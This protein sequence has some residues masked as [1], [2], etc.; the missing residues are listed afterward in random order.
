MIFM[1]QKQQTLPILYSYFR[2]SCA[3]RVRLALHLKKIDF[4]YRAVHLLKNGGEQNE[5]SYR[6]LNPQGEVPFWV[7]DQVQMAQSLPIIQYLDERWP[8]PR[9]I[10]P[11][12]KK[13]Y[14]ALELCELINSGIQPL[15]NLK[16]LQRIESQLKGS[17]SDKESWV[18][19]FVSAGLLALENKIKN[20]P[21]YKG[22]FSM[23]DDLSVVDLFI[24]PQMF[25]AD[26][27]KVNLEAYPILRAINQKCL[28]LPEV[29]LAHPKL[30]PDFES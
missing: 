23:G 22:N 29:Q 27:F 13:K 9:L 15:Q 20:S 24:V 11:E 30:Q 2:S 5:T 19:H 17:A 7:D 18:H 4:E 14:F 16:V 12:I 10:P 26:R 3:Y 1:T 6:Q 25:S 8:T 21:Y 28:E